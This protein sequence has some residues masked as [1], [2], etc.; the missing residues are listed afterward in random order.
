MT[1]RSQLAY[2][3]RLAAALLHLPSATV[4]KKR[5][6]KHQV[7]WK[8]GADEKGTYAVCAIQ[9][10]TGPFIQEW[11]THQ[12]LLGAE[13]IYLYDNSELGTVGWAHFMRAVQPF[14]ELGLV[15][16]VPWWIQ[17]SANS[18]QQVEA[19]RDCFERAR[20]HF[21]WLAFI[22]TDEYPVIHEPHT[23]C[24]N[25]F[26]SSLPDDQGG[27]VLRWRGFA[28][29]G[30]AVHDHDKLF[31]EQYRY[32]AKHKSFAY[33]KSIV[34]VNRTEGVLHAHKATYRHGFV[35]KDAGGNVVDEWWFPDRVPKDAHKHMELRH[36]W[37]RDLQT[38][39]YEKVR[40]PR[41]LKNEDHL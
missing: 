31:L 40:R 11:L 22:D 20:P 4:L 14:M 39:L 16:I 32:E 35:P 13:K 37:A 38:G 34:N 3:K 24:M 30:Q 26:L 27:L 17:G 6:Y 25:R 7:C 36:Y 19:Q 9:Q 29:L 2:E 10:S 12:L 23:T 41:V 21:K 1:K 18:Y 15:E 8:D 33:L 28:P 5:L